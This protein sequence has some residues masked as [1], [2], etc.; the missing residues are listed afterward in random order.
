[1]I[2]VF[3]DE[4]SIVT[5]ATNATIG[6]PIIDTATLT[7]GE[8]ATGTIKFMAYSPNDFTCTGAPLF[9][10][11]AVPVSGNGQYSSGSFTPEA[12]GPYRWIAAY[13][14]D[15]DTS[16]VSGVCN[17]PGETSTVSAQTPATRR[18]PH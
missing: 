6:Q 11:P 15:D 14:G 3:L 5:A 17:D 18:Q 1:M 16:P 2:S 12:V 9:T 8:S 10:S 13:S 4:P 7:K